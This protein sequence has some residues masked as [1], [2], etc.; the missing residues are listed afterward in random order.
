[1][2]IGRR[3]LNLEE[4]QVHAHFIANDGSKNRS[5]K[6]S[7][8]IFSEVAAAHRAAMIDCRNREDVAKAGR[9]TW[10]DPVKRWIAQQARRTSF[11]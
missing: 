7:A 8:I 9:S 3:K 4:L 5:A 11:G 10:T 6:N 2:F 1:M